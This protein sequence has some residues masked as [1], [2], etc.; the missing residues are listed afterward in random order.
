MVDGG[1]QNLSAVVGTIPG[2]PAAT[3]P[4]CKGDMLLLYIVS[5]TSY[6]PWGKGI[7]KYCKGGQPPLIRSTPVTS[8]LERSFSRSSRT[9]T[10]G[11]R[12]GASP[13][14]QSYVASRFP[15]SNSGYRANINIVQRG[16]TRNN[17]TFF[18]RLLT[19]L[20]TV[21][22]LWVPCELSSRKPEKIVYH[23]A[24]DLRED[25][26]GGNFLSNIWNSAAHSPHG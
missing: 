24:A 2:V 12:T 9:S 7:G 21:H 20:W 17:L 3:G 4:R 15:Q 25:V 5:Y 23:K 13:Q 11:C 19:S 1:G 26:W 16:A 14:P 18:S 8:S 6:K 10:F 22:N